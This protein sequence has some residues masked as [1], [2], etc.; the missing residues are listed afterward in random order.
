[1]RFTPASILLASVLALT[2]S[3]TLGQKAS[4]PAIAAAEADPRAAAWVEKGK[5]ALATEDIAKAREAYETALLLAPADKATYLAL[6]KIARLQQMP[7]K[8]I[9]YYSRVLDDD[10]DNQAALQGE[11]LAMMEKGAT[12][13][14]RETLARLRDVCKTSCASAEPLI[15]AIAA[16]APKVVS[17][18]PVKVIPT[19]PTEQPQQQ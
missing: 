16:G 15:A 17:A 9:R 10:P 2:A 7:G 5:Q 4:R 19:E 12:E 14:A 6:A 11:G 1:M 18:E 3:S 13:S 8:A